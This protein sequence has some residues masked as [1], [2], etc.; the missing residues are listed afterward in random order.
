[1]GLGSPV[2][3]IA[4]PALKVM[5]KGEMSRKRIRDDRPASLP[6]QT[7]PNC[8]QRENRSGDHVSSMAAFPTCVFS[9]R[10][11]I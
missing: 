10:D 6:V 5:V 11:W 8:Y 9:T 2:K 7:V 3:R 4:P 1:M